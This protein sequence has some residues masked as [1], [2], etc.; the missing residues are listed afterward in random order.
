MKLQRGPFAI[1][2]GTLTT[3]IYDRAEWKTE[4]E[5]PSWQLF[6]DEA[7]KLLS[8]ALSRGV[9]EMYLPELTRRASQRDSALNELRA[10]F[11]FD[12]NGF[13]VTE[14]RPVGEPPKEGEFA[15]RCPSGESIF[16]EVKSPGW[17]ME[18]SQ[19]ERLAGRTK[20]PKYQNGEGLMIANEDAITFAVE[21]AYPKFSAT[22]S[23]L[24]VVADD[25]FVSLEHG[26]EI[27][28]DA[29]LYDPRRGG[30]FTSSSY[31]RLGGV[32]CFWWSS[33][34]DQM[35]YEMPLLVNPLVLPSCALPSV[36]VQEFRGRTP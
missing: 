23:N 31:E 2:L 34:S 6:A 35:Q 16:V 13:P 11:F 10:A 1:E 30:K 7:E 33:K 12:K 28:A 4:D 5:Y 9:F 17:E 8:F 32:G 29:A 15:I 19:A 27:W 26:T 18:L 36:F 24:L 20:E 3:A 25:L 21:K 22:T 14:W